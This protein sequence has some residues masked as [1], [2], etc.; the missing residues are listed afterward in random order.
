[1]FKLTVFIYFFWIIFK[2]KINFNSKSFN[3]KFVLFPN[4]VEYLIVYIL[5]NLEE[6]AETDKMFHH[7]N[8]SKYAT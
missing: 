4:Q 3:R 2:T 1:M 8:L 5:K 6:C 7:Q